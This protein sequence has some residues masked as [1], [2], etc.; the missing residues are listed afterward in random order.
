LRPI[1]IAALALAM[2]WLCSAALALFQRR[3]RAAR[4]AVGPLPP[5]LDRHPPRR[6]HRDR[7][8]AAALREPRGCGVCGGLCWSLWS[9]CG[10]PGGGRGSRLPWAPG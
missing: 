5:Y 6:R 3:H 7:P 8:L 1:V 2:I 9:V 10:Q 4:G